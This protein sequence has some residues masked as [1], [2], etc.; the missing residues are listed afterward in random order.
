MQA[1]MET[2]FDCTYLAF[3]IIIGI[4]MIKGAKDNKERKLFGI[5]AVVLGCGDAFHLIPR[6]IAL[7]VTNTEMLTVALGAGKLITSITMTIFY[8]IL[9][10]IC[11]IRYEVKDNKLM[12]Y[13]IYGLAAVRILLCLLPQNDWFSEDSP[14]A[15]GIYRNIPF[16]I[17]GIIII[18]MYYKKAKEKKDRQ[19]KYMWLAIALSFALYI[20]V[21][22][23]V[24]KIPLLGMLMIPKTC[25]YVWIVLMG[26]REI[27][28]KNS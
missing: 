1:V 24:D 2:I 4:R 7:W 26:Y 17:M 19:F 16:V 5:M 10:R 23:W 11:L 27:K 9:F 13:S 20:P 25:A 18:V 15:W 12:S 8:I 22:L 28:V 6:M 14:V 21:V 3:A